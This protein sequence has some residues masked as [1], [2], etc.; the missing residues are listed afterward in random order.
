MPDSFRIPPLPPSHRYSWWV[1]RG[2]SGAAEEAG[3][4]PGPAEGGRRAPGSAPPLPEALPPPH[5]GELCPP[6]QPHP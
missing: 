1:A 6:C 4:G 5:E 3:V 2:G